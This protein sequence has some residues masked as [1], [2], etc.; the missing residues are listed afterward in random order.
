MFRKLLKA[1][2]LCPVDPVQDYLDGKPQN[3]SR[4]NMF[5]MAA[6]AGAGIAVGVAIPA[7]IKAVP[8]SPMPNIAVSRSSKSYEEG[9]VV[10]F[11]GDCAF[12]VSPFYY[13]SCAQWTKEEIG[14]MKAQN[15]KPFQL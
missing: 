6:G 7:S 13:A 10:Y 5:K 8:G 15:K 9:T 2:G 14:A 12:T 1:F 3:E 4:R 11:S